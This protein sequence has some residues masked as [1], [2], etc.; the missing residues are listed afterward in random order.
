MRKKTLLMT[1]LMLIG[2]SFAN[3]TDVVVGTQ[4]SNKL[5]NLFPTNPYTAYSLTEQIYTPAEIGTNGS[6]TSISF[7][8][9]WT[10]ESVDE[11]NMPGL[12]LYMKHTTSS[13][14]NNNTDMIALNESNL[15]W[16]GNFTAPSVDYKGWV[17]IELDEPFQYNGTDNLLIAFYDTNPQKTEANTNKF[18][19]VTTTENS[20]LA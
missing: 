5:T 11:L 14:F 20:A 10:S 12:K 15:V 7:Y 17:T 2:F 3:A 4:E 18:Y 19:Y 8:R 6:I 13:K 1:L 16:E 9:D